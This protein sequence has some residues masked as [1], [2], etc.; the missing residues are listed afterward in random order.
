[1]KGG[2]SGI[3]GNV[4][5]ITPTG[6]WGVHVC[7]CRCWRFH[8]K[9]QQRGSSILLGN[10]GAPFT[11][12]Q[13]TLVSWSLEL[14]WD[15]VRF[16]KR[17]ERIFGSGWACCSG[18]EGWRNPFLYFTQ[19]QAWVQRLWES[20]HLR[21]SRLK[22]CALLTGMKMVSGIFRRKLDVSFQ[23]CA[24]PMG[25]QTYLLMCRRRSDISWREPWSCSQGEKGAGGCTVSRCGI[26]DMWYDGGGI[27][28]ALIVRT[29]T[30]MEHEGE[31]KVGG[32]QAHTL[33]RRDT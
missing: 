3:S 7:P 22:W 5:P 30:K 14:N 8:M 32:V 18:L 16:R 13:G 6:Y 15:A 11:S 21:W 23:W 20:V 25:A 1:M 33:W 2:G 19:E 27:F 4:V 9:F 17:L 24:L 29:G 12:S 31:A 10:W 26:N 28:A